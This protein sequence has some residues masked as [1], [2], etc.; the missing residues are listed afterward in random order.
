MAKHRF[1][2][3]AYCARFKK[4]CSTEKR[5]IT[6][7]SNKIP[8]DRDDP[9]IG[10]PPDDPGGVQLERAAN[11]RLLYSIPNQLYPIVYH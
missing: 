1:G 2:S 9:Y 8:K 11:D 3:L 4:K 7:K 6:K 10:G 5:D